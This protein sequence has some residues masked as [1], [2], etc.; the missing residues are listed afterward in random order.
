MAAGFARH[1]VAVAVSREDVSIAADLA[2]MWSV[3]WPTVIG[4]YRARR[5]PFLVMERAFLGDQLAAVSLG[6]TGLKG[7]ADFCNEDVPDD[8]WQR[9]AGLMQPWRYDDAGYVLVVGQVP[10]DTAVA[11][12]NIGHWAQQTIYHVRSLLPDVEVVYRPHPADLTPRLPNGA[13]ISEGP[14]AADLAGAAVAVTFN[15]T[16]GVDAALAGVPVVAMDEGSMAWP[17]AAHQVSQHSLLEQPE[18]DRE[19]W[20][21]RLAYTQWA[22]AEISAGDAWARLQRGPVELWN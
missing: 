2:V 10:S 13:R 15:S 17:V 16:V 14:L 1:G 5:R 8:R 22:H 4:D 20:G 7:R 21:E 18:P 12:T 9:F 3:R 6:Y 11:G 19:E